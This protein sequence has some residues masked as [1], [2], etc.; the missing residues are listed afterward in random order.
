MSS[1][2]TLNRYANSDL[3][4]FINLI[5]GYTTKPPGAAY[6]FGQLF[7]AWLLEDVFPADVTEARFK[8][9]RNMWEALL[10]NKF[11]RS[12]LEDARTEQVQL[13]DDPE[14][15]LPCTKPICGC[16]KAGC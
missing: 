4:E 10:S 2:R 14:T 11:A 16:R 12:V 1:Y 13:W 7:H 5:V 15:G 3:S 6:Q 8:Q 9:L